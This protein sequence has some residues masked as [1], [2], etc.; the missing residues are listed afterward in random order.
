MQGSAVARKKAQ[1]TAAKKSLLK[2]SLKKH[3]EAPVDHIFVS[4]Y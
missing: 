1:P 2:G 3:F 4:Y